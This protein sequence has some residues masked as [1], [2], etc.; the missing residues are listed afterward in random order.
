MTDLEKEELKEF[1]KK[2]KKELEAKEVR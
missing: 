1:M 2:L